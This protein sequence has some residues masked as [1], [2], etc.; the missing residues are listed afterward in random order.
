MRFQAFAVFSCVLIM[1]GQ[2]PLGTV[3]GLAVDASGGAVTA[4]SVTLTNND[5]GVRRTTATNSS[6]AYAFPGLPPGTYRLGADAKGF[7]PLET[8]GFAVEAYRTMRQDLNFEVASASTEVVV[9]EA[10]SAVVQLESPAVGSNL[11][12]R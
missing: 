10:A 4:A 2:T 6:G 3:S 1:H 8:R 12:P 5:T 11:A 9:T 7:R